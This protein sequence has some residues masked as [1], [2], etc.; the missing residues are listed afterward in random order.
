MNEPFAYIPELLKEIETLK[1]TVKTQQEGVNAATII[2]DDLR[3]ENKL[4]KKNLYLTELNNEIAKYK[5]LYAK[6]LDDYIKLYTRYE[7]LMAKY[8]KL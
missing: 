1:S 2:I 4:L 8:I 6:S 3:K 5:N 7:Q